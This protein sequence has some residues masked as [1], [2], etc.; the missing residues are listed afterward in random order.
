MVGA[1]EDHFSGL[2]SVFHHPRL[3]QPG[4]SASHGALID[5]DRVSQIAPG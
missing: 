4:I 3:P 5:A 2:V 1:L